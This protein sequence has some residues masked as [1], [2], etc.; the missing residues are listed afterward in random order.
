MYIFHVYFPCQKL[1]NNLLNQFM[2]KMVD[3]LQYFRIGL[4]LIGLGRMVGR[5][6]QFRLQR[7]ERELSRRA[8]EELYR[9]KVLEKQK[10]RLLQHLY[11]ANEIIK[12]MENNM[13]NLSDFALTIINQLTQHILNQKN[14]EL[15]L[16]Q[17]SELIN[18]LQTIIYTNDYFYPKRNNVMVECSICLDTSCTK[19]IELSCKHAFHQS[20][21]ETW[22]CT[23]GRT[24]TFE[25]PL[26]KNNITN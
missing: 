19:F 2:G 9:H 13:K 17:L 5:F 12:F 18:K 6:R 11:M 4:G 26:C 7:H 14:D 21:I 15:Y 25:C 23:L 8:I 3:F 24:F 1:N 22:F 20:C 16:Q 10:E